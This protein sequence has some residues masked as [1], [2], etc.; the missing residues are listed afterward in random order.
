MKYLTHLFVSLWFV[1]FPALDRQ[2]VYRCPPC[3]SMC[4]QLIFH[5][6]GTCQHCGM[7]LITQEEENLTIAFYLQDG[8]EILDFAGSMEVFSYAGYEVF[9]VSKTK[10]PIYAQRVLK[11]LP[12][13]SIGDVVR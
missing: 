7:D 8:V 11:V 13:Y 1:A 12:D 3:N 6:A 10:E 9:T 4:D 2:E 5:Q